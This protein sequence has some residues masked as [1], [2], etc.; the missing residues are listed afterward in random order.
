[1]DD[2]EPNSMI[3]NEEFPFRAIKNP[4]TSKDVSRAISAWPSPV[5]NESIDASPNHR[6]RQAGSL[7]YIEGAARAAYHG[8][9]LRS[10][11]NLPLNVCGASVA[12]QTAVSAPS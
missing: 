12:N 4:L 7:C 10:R 5:R 11:K 9:T 8:I 3:L 1:M 2:E 6:S